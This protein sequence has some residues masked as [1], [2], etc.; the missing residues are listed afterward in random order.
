MYRKVRGSVFVLLLALILPACST[1]TQEKVNEVQRKP[2]TSPTLAQA[3]TRV[4]KRKVAIARFTDE[5]HHGSSFLV[6]KNYERVGKQAMD[7]LSARLAETGKFLMFERSDL[8]KVQ[9][10]RSLANMDARTVG[11]DYLV[12][13]SVS[14]FGR[15]ATSEVGIFSRNKKQT[16]RATVNVRLI[17]VAT[18]QIVFSQ[19]GSGEASSE[20]NRVFGVGE[21]A[22]YDSEL[23]DKAL[24]AAISKLVSN[25]VENLLDKPWQAYIVARQGDQYLVTGGKSQGLS[26]GDELVVMAPGKKV[27][28]AQTGMTI[29]LPGTEKARIR[30]TQ[31]LGHGNNEV[32]L[33]AVTSGNLAGADINKLVVRAP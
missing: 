4:L 9:A 6:D 22:G 1:V 23:D 13:G 7:V 11:A 12:V 26:I 25:L 5:T 21:T 3:N 14:E 33:C 29:E 15:T 2:Q 24:S 27:N 17:D 16:A 32:S 28:N 8:G 31:L 19:E 20:A 18:G 30:V 10:E